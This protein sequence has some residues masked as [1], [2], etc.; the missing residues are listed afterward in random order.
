MNVMLVHYRVGENDGVSLEMEKWRN[1]LQQLG[2]RVAYLAGSLGR[3]EGYIVPSIRYD[4]PE[5]ARIHTLAF[6]SPDLPEKEFIEFFS[7]YKEAIKNE[8]MPVL[9]DFK[10]DLLIVN[11]MWSLAYNL[12]AGVALAEV[13]NLLN[14][15]AIAHHHDFYWER[16]RYSHPR[17]HFVREILDTYFPPD[18]PR[19]KHVVINLLA[20]NE[21][22]KRKG[23]DA[24]VIP[25][26]FDFDQLPWTIDDFNSELREKMRISEND[27]VFLQATRI[28]RR[29]AIELSL[30]FL[31]AFQQRCLKKLTG[32]AIYNG[33]KITT[34]SKAVLLLAGQPEDPEY[35]DE[36]KKLGE[37]LKV[38]IVEAFNFI[39]ARRSHQPK[40]YSLW[41][42]YAISDVVMYPSIL[43]GWG[44]QFIEGI[45]SKRPM[46]VFE[47][48]VFV[49]DILPMGFWFISLGREYRNVD[50]F[51]RI[52]PEVIN[53]AL[54]ELCE[55]LADIS[56]TPKRLEANFLI[57]KKRLSLT[58]L[59]ELI[60]ELME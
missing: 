37:K 22:K 23:V 17:Y 43:E 29:K 34:E 8:L 21:L 10:A 59:K 1:V 46:V 5:N 12:A 2:H 19:I 33:R 25:N 16:D 53:R 30:E 51:V 26:V 52:N 50:G 47:Y 41:D 40:R 39:S 20:K 3:E 24:K 15:K 44:N 13:L 35:L 55:A 28:V 11:N 48:P 9:N 54:D 31:A 4:H 38:N 32:K 58:Y 56:E 7:S 27:I 18:D 14:L 6:E 36:L 49:S 60:E 57:G 42:A 45:F